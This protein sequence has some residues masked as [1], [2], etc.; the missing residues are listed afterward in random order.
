ME[1]NVVESIATGYLKMAAD[2]D[3]GVSRDGKRRF[4]GML[5]DPLYADHVEQLKTLASVTATSVVKPSWTM[6]SL[7][8][9][10]GCF[11]KQGASGVIKSAPIGKYRAVQLALGILKDA[12]WSI[13]VDGSSMV[14]EQTGEGREGWIGMTPAEVWYAKEGKKK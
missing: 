13:T 1:W 6:G 3:Y 14:G 8:P 7:S 2:P 11:F 5:T 12:G 9:D 4:N 10:G